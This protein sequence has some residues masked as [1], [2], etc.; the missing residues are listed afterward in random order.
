M[1]YINGLVKERRN[2]S[3]LAM[4]LRLSCT[5]PSIYTY[6]SELSQLWC[7]V[8]C[9]ATSHMQPFS[10]KKMHSNMSAKWQL[11]RSGF[12]VLW[13]GFCG[14]CFKYLQNLGARFSD[15]CGAKK[16]WIFLLQLRFYCDSRFCIPIWHHAISCHLGIL[17]KLAYIWCT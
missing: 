9:S 11:F 7:L 2:S 14:T 10:M 13:Y 6:V 3:A 5:K 17:D 15:S 8:A 16:C 12:N 1:I 4:E